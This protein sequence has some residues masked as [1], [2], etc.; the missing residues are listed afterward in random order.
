MSIICFRT[1]YLF[2]IHFTST[3]QLLEDGGQYLQLILQFHCFPL[4]GQLLLWTTVWR[5][6][7]NG[8]QQTIHIAVQGLSCIV[9]HFGFMLCWIFVELLT[10]K[11]FCHTSQ[12]KA[13][14]QL[15]ERMCQLSQLLRNGKW[16]PLLDLNIYTFKKLSLY[17]LYILVFLYTAQEV[18]DTA[19]LQISPVPAGPVCLC[20]SLDSATERKSV[21]L[22]TSYCR[23]TQLLQLLKILK[24]L[25][26]PPHLHLTTILNKLK[27][28][29]YQFKFKEKC[30]LQIKFLNDKS[31]QKILLQRGFMLLCALV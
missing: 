1:K 13:T 9:S 3:S 15:K 19:D 5:S 14:L 25:F 31:K 4:E 12:Y 30:H 2:S 18:C 22:L 16:K 10:G 7:T 24:T 17:V 29:N 27:L 28:I 8:G 6:Q 20:C 23:A 11:S 21:N 26:Y